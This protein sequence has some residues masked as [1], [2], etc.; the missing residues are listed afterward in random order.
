MP[1]KTAK[2]ILSNKLEDLSTENFKKFR[3]ELV[4]RKDGVK[5]SQV[6][7]KDYM[8]VSE[9]MINVYTER[10]A[11]KVAEE[12]L[13]EIRC[14]QDADELGK[15]LHWIWIR[16]PSTRRSAG[17]NKLLDCFTLRMQHV[18]STKKN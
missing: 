9:V 5:M 13:R 16:L 1:P 17:K 15:Y 10:K 11:L 4:D 8:K 18:D 2:K 14:Q 12:I 6:E 7:D 3:I